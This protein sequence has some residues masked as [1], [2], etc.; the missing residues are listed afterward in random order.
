M[1]YWDTGITYTGKEGG[2]E[3]REDGNLHL[4]AEHRPS[5]LVLDLLMRMSC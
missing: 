5:G 1:L 2:G 4:R 3:I